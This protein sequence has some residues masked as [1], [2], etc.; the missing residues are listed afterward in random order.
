MK[1]GLLISTSILLILLATGCSNHTT[2]TTSSKTTTTKV[3]QK[4]A[5]VSYQKLTSSA[6]KQLAF[7]FQEDP[8]DSGYD[9]SMK[10]TNKT[11]KTVK[12]DRAKFMILVSNSDSVSSAKTGTFT[13]K[14]GQ[15][16]TVDQLFQN[17][18]EQIL[19]NN[20]YFIYSNKN[21][22]LAKINF[23]PAN[24]N[25]DDT[26]TKTTA[27]NNNNTQTNT[28]QSTTGNTQQQA[29]NNQQ[30][31]QNAAV[32]T[33]PEMAISLFAHSYSTAAEAIQVTPVSNGYEVTA[34]D[35]FKGNVITSA[36]DIISPDGT[37]GTYDQLRQSTAHDPNGWNAGN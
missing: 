32:I 31:N 26:T 4:T 12:F 29:A 17:V 34:P 2:K 5:P 8:A 36:G 27:N 7:K 15:T 16:K 25:V 22:K 33:S 24:T 14:A 20:N 21:N 37:T 10:V 18:N 30:T 19:T 35:M 6:K 3:A 1:K 28:N 23:K 9:I 13:L 11:K